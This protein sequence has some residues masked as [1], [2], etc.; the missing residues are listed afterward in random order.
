MANPSQERVDVTNRNTEVQPFEFPGT[1]QNVR[2]LT[3][4][5]D[6]WFILTD[7]AKILGY[8]DAEMPADCFATLR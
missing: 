5:D 8:R 3:I 7:V 2:G 6:P 4:D 1:H